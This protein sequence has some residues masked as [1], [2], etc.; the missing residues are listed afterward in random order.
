MSSSNK[1][2][3]QVLTLLIEDA[4]GVTEYLVGFLHVGEHSILRP[5]AARVHS[6][7]NHDVSSVRLEEALQLQEWAAK[8]QVVFREGRISDPK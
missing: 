7:Q 6:G 4:D 5:L 8:N 2:S 3:S 1:S